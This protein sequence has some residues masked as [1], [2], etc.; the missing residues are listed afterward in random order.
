MSENIDDI[1]KKKLDIS[2]ASKI[3]VDDWA[4]TEKILIQKEL[5]GYYD[6]N[7]IIS[8]FQKVFKEFEISS[9]DDQEEDGNKNKVWGLVEE[10]E[11]KKTKSGKAYLNV[12]CSGLSDKLYR[13]RVWDTSLKDN[14]TWIPGSCNVFSLQFDKEY[15]YNLNKY[16]KILRLT[17]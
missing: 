8:K 6:K 16:G 4:S 15:G 3:T 12:S 13:F 10:V 17:K 2:E 14:T 11:E 5:L 9:V 7:L 1:R